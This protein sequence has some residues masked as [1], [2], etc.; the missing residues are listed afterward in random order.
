MTYLAL[1]TETNGSWSDPRLVQ[2]SFELVDDWRVV[3]ECTMIVKPE[4]FEISKDATGIHG[5]SHELAMRVGVPISVALTVFSRVARV[6]GLFAI[7]CHSISFDVGRVLAGEI[8]HAGNDPSWSHLLKLPTFCTMEAMRPVC[9][10]PQKGPGFKAPKLAEAFLH[11]FGKPL[12]GAHRA[13]R[14]RWACSRVFA[15]Q[16][17]QIGGDPW[18]EKRE[19]I[20]DFAHCR[21]EQSGDLATAADIKILPLDTFGPPKSKLTVP[22]AQS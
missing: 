10:L 13:D 6:D 7:V 3:Q 19:Q 12:V 2:L 9:K 14:D 22:N 1:D 11:C 8:V 5:I 16:Q 21:P 18:P 20:M 4:G 17:A 15:W